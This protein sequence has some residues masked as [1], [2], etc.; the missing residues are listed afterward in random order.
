MHGVNFECSTLYTHTALTLEADKSFI[1]LF[2]N[3]VL[4]DQ[5]LIDYSVLKGK[6]VDSERKV[7]GMPDSGPF[8]NLV[9]MTKAD[10]QM[11]SECK[12][13]VDDCYRNAEPV[14]SPS[15]QL[16]CLQR[17]NDPLHED[18]LI[19]VFRCGQAHKGFFRKEPKLSRRS[20]EYCFTIVADA[21]CTIVFSASDEFVAVFTED[22]LELF[23]I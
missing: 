7:A 6:V 23:E 16:V 2:Q 11:R 14:F 18:T 9:K 20:E 15:Q 21:G 1:I 10:L 5:T 19:D 3:Q 12:R 8:F 13:K 22:K 4:T 17:F